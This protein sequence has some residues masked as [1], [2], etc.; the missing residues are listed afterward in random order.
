MQFTPDDLFIALR[1]LD[2]V[3]LQPLKFSIQHDSAPYGNLRPYMAER[4]DEGL[5][6]C[7]AFKETSR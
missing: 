6:P 5:G 4:P 1:L 3:F 7:K 2:A